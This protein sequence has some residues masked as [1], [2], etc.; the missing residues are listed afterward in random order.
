LKTKYRGILEG[1]HETVSVHFRFNHPGEPD[2]ARLDQM[3]QPDA[4]WY[5]N[6]MEWLFDSA[7]SVF[8]FFSED[9]RQLEPLIM[10][11]MLEYPGLSFL[12]I[13]EN[14]ALSLALMSMCKHHIVATSMFSFWGLVLHWIVLWGDD[15]DDDGDDDDDDDDDDD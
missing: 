12:V 3:Q 13:D 1:S 7:T 15:D 14:F 5:L 4:Q 11:I 2:A 10:R 6:A 9:A 8:L